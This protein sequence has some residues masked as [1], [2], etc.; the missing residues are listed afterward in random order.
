MHRPSVFLEAM[1]TNKEEW[2]CNNFAK[3]SME[4]QQ[5]HNIFVGSTAGTFTFSK[6]NVYFE[7]GQKYFN[8]WD[9]HVNNEPSVNS[10]LFEYFFQI[11]VIQRSQIPQIGECYDPKVSSQKCECRVDIWSHHCHDY[12]LK[13][14]TTLGSSSLV[15]QLQ[16]KKIS[17]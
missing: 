15:I 7:Y 16:V 13:H 11:L 12:Q 3:L 2:N 5:I 6:I 10:N 14:L 4:G 9:C 8:S 1:H 17:I